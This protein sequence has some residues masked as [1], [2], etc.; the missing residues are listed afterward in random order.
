LQVDFLGHGQG[1]DE[2]ECVEIGSARYRI[3]TPRRPDE[4]FALDERRHGEA[5][6]AR[7]GEG[8]GDLDPP[9]LVSLGE[10][11]AGVEVDQSQAARSCSMAA[12]ISSA[13]RRA[14]HRGR[15]PGPGRALGVR[16]SHTLLQ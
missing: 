7:L 4:A 2:V 8:L 16:P 14:W 10:I 12:S 11:D 13:L 6:I 9:A 1:E 5:G 15:E 3:A